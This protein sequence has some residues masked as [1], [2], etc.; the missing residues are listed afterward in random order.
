MHLK[1]LYLAFLVLNNLVC[2]SELFLIFLA[3]KSQVIKPLGKLASQTFHLHNRILEILDLFPASTDLVL[4]LLDSHIP[5]SDLI[6]L[7]RYLPLHI[8]LLKLHVT[9]GIVLTLNSLLQVV[10]IYIQFGGG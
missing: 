8:L 10:Y 6:L 1:L 2:I 7:D 9:Q 4:H 5:L 3:V